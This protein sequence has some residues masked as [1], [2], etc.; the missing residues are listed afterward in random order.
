[1]K[2]YLSIVT[3]ASAISLASS[4][5]PPTPPLAPLAPPPPLPIRE[6][7]GG[8]GAPP[9][10][11]QAIERELAHLDAQNQRQVEQAQR[12]VEQAQRQVEQAQRKAQQA[13]QQMMAQAGGGG[14][15]GVPGAAQRFQGIFQRSPGSRTGKAIVI[16]SSEIDPKTQAG[17]EEDMAVMSHILEKA[18]GAGGR[19]RASTA[20]SIDLMFLPGS[21]EPENFYLEGYGAVFMLNVNF[22]LLAPPPQ[23]AEEKQPP[24]GDSEWEEAKQELYGPHDG[25]P[26]PP[27]GPVEEYS[28]EKVSRLKDALLEA[29]QNVKNIRGL[30]DDESVT[31]CVFGGMAQ[32]SVPRKARSARR[33]SGGGEQANPREIRGSDQPAQRTVMTMRVKKSDAEGKLKPEEFRKK[34]RVTVYTAR[35][36]GGG[37]VGAFRLGGLGD[38]IA[39]EVE[40]ALSFLKTPDGAFKWRW[41][42]E[43]A[44]ENE[45]EN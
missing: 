40:N 12:N 27:S 17:L 38:A 10:D 18:T 42:Q 37:G 13:Q 3:F 28:E 44:R 2:T 26:K 22:P 20:M 14:V 19:S 5:A 6:S 36:G 24:P 9:D 41:D 16:R 43:Q 29:L 11:A 15:V 45:E 7:S 25:G 30:K 4:Q 1:M 35:A 8:P 21:S 39:G 33:S 31:V 23:Q 34:A 32:P